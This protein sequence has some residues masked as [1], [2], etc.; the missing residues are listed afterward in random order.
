MPDQRE[1]II[2]IHGVHSRRIL[3]GTKTVELRRRFPAMAPG[4]R[5]WIYETMP[6]GAI[7]GHAT[8]AG[9]DRG[10]PEAL[11]ERH[12]TNTCVALEDFMTYLDGCAEGVA[13]L[14]GDARATPLLSRLALKT[15]RAR[16]QPPQVMTLLTPGERLALREAASEQGRTPPSARAPRRDPRQYALPITP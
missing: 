2:S 8:V 14:L 3:A 13:I 4:S 6:T 7:V 15:V 10:S 16:F 11:W 1:A 9:F 12:G 5:L